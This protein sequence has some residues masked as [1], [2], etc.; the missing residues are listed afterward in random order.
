MATKRTE[1]EVFNDLAKLCITEGYAHVIAYLCTRD[2]T[3]SYKD[4]LIAKDFEHQ[5]SRERLIRTEISTLIGLM[6]KEEVKLGIPQPSKFQGL[7]DNTES[8]LHELHETMTTSWWSGFSNPVEVIQSGADPFS[9]GAAMREPIF[10]S[11]ESAYDFQYREL[12]GRKYANDANWFEK[13]KGFSLADAKKIVDAVSKIQTEHS[14]SSRESIQLLPP[15]Q[16]SMLPA[17]KVTCDDFT[18]RTGLSVDVI[19]KFLKAFSIKPGSGSNVRFDSLN[20]FNQVNATPFIHIDETSFLLF[21]NYSLYEAFY[22]SPFFWMYDDKAYRNE[23]TQNRGNFLEHYSAER[24]RSVFGEARVYENVHIWGAGRDQ[25]G[26]IDVLVVFSNRAI[27]LQAKT[28]RLTIE[29]RKGND[30]QLKDDFKKS[31]QDSYDQGLLCAKCLNQPEFVYKD[32]S[33]RRLELPAFK[34][35]YI[36]CVVSDHYPA[37]G[38]Q[39][40]QFLKSEETEVIKPPFVMDVFLLDVLCEML[41]S[42]LYFLSYVNRRVGYS[43]RIFSSHELVVLSYHLRKNLWVEDEL[44]MIYL[45]D[46]ISIELDIAMMVRRVGAPGADTPSGILTKLDGSPLKRL[47]TQ[48]EHKEDPVTIDF[49]FLLLSMSEDALV[50]LGITMGEML[51]KAKAQKNHHDLTIAVADSGITMHF[52]LDEDRVAAEKLRNHC[53]KRKYVCKAKSWFGICINQENSL[54]RFGLELTYPWVQSDMM[55][56]ATGRML[57][58]Y[59]SLAEARSLHVQRKIGR[60]DPCSCGSGKKFKKCCLN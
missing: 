2:N 33:G 9:S 40:R 25:V 19:D 16:W 13:E 52:N 7:I 35:I 28:K 48:I 23:A 47:L 12:A 29:A 5:S 37:L 55:D 11:G 50:D 6:C 15:E 17:F 1:E 24:L 59:K 8:L 43:D 36:F 45:D 10:Y 34:E 53:E 14:H 51:R 54:P 38:F 57:A 56:E 58:G 39:A 26:E 3:I 21:Q 44:S 22:E 30:L 49:G 4:K 20:A 42:P 41:P 60:N 46:S 18:S 27:I 32:V 31:I